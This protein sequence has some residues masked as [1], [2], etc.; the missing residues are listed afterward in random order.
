MKRIIGITGGIG[1]GKSQVLDIL[2]KDFGAG[3]IQTDQVARH[4][5][6]PGMEGYGKIVEFLGTGFLSP[7]GTINQEK[8]GERIFQDPKALETVNRI[9]HPMVWE[10]TEIMAREAEEEL[11]IVESALMGKKQ[12]EQYHELWYVYTGI[13][14]RIRRLMRDRGYSREKC[15][16]IMANQKNESEF[17]AIC[18]RVIDNNGSVE[19]TRRQIKKALACQDWRKKTR[20]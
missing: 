4:L 3:I 1:S 7:N 9:I 2:K 18:S 17:R 11:I 10:S 6:E 8:L 13:E 19:E 12:Q 14:E 5:M 15:L 20:T 16:G